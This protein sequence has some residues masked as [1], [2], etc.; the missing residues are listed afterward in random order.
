M[1][2]T[3]G[4]LYTNA[5]YGFTTML[6][7][8]LTDYKPDLL[9]VAFDKGRIT[10]R[11][12]AYQQYKAQRQATPGELSE[13][14]PLVRE[15]LDA[16]GITTIEEQGYEADDILGTLADKAAKQ[17]CEVMIVT[18]DRDALQLIGPHITVLLTRRNF[19]NGDYG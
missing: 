12:E 10:F 11:N 18:G 2:R 5:V 17:G 9:A 13:Q 3:A 1:L 14:F 16:F 15:L 8:I 6:V 19:R 4:G 7:K